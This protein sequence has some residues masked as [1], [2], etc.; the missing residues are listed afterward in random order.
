MTKAFVYVVAAAGPDPDRIA[1]A[2]P[3]EVDERLIFFGP[4]KKRLRDRLREQYLASGQDVAVPQD[5]LYLVGLSPS[6]AG[7]PR[8]VLWAGKVT[9][10]M[11]FSHAHRELQDPRFDKMRQAPLSPLHLRPI[12][13]DGKLAGYEHVS[14]EHIERDGWVADILR[15]RQSHLVKKVGRQLLLEP[16]A[17]PQAFDR[18]ICFLLDNILFARRGTRPGVRI[19]EEGASVFRRA[20]PDRRVDANAVFGYRKDGSTEGRTGSYLE[21][22]G[23]LADELIEWIRQRTKARSARSQP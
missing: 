22:N 20:Q 6:L 5:D 2:V 10:F 23:S 21:L 14:L 16:F 1:C 15:N 13:H 8:T 4:C 19:D 12:E 9:R 18:D 3:W 7:H 11:T 17:T